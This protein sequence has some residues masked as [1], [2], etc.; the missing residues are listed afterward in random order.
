MRRVRSCWPTVEQELLLKASLLKGE[1]GL[2]AWKKWR[3]TDFDKIDYGS[4]RLI[5]LL[6]RNLLSQHIQAPVMDRYRGVYRSFW[7]RNQLL[8]HKVRPVLAALHEAGVE[9]MLFKG[10][11]LLLRCDMDIALRPMED[12]DFIIHRDDV[13]TVLSIVKKLG[14]WPKFGDTLINEATNEISFRNESGQFIDI[15]FH[16]LLYAEWG[17]HELTYWNGALQSDFLGVPV[18]VM[19]DTDH[20]IH[21]LVHGLAWNPVPSIRWVSDAMLL[22][23]SLSS[24]KWDY[25][26]EQSR[27]LRVTIPMYRGLKYLKE[28]MDVVVIPEEVLIELKRCR[29]SLAERMAHNLRTEPVLPRHMNEII[30][31]ILTY[32]L[33]RPRC[34]FPGILRYFQLLWGLDHVWQV[35]C[36][37]L[38]KLFKGVIAHVCRSDSWLLAK[39]FLDRVRGEYSLRKS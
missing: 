12:V 24:I 16:A 10:A 14:W 34:P 7:A 18:K 9:I 6:Y 25:L 2:S 8:F 22:L 11:G 28:K 32:Y 4:L 30:L 39:K 19:V 35:P 37:G 26:V 23:D 31:R 3:E 15:H 29:T 33:Y 38:Q 21:V 27:K 20:L 13:N 1:K 5:P 17:I 36:E